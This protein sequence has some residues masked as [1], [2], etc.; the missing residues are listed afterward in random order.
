MLFV[1]AAV[2]V[3]LGIIIGRKTVN[4]SAHTND[5]HEFREN[6]SRV[7][8]IA[9]ETTDQRRTSS[10]HPFKDHR[11]LLALEDIPSP[12]QRLI[13]LYRALDDTTPATIKQ[14]VDDYL[15]MTK[16]TQNRLTQLTGN[17]GFVNAMMQRYGKLVGADSVRHLLTM[18]ELNHL[19]MSIRGF[20]GDNPQAAIDYFTNEKKAIPYDAMRAFANEIALA[21]MAK[22][23]SLREWKD[24]MAIKNEHN[25]LS[26]GSFVRFSAAT[27]ALVE[28]KQLNIDLS[29][30]LDMHD[31]NYLIGHLPEYAQLL[32]AKYSADYETE[33]NASTIHFDRMNP[34]ERIASIRN[35]LADSTLDQSRKI[36]C[37]QRYLSPTDYS[38]LRKD[39]SPI[40]KT[41]DH[42][43]QE[44]LLASNASDVLALNFDV[45]DM[46]SILQDETHFNERLSKLI[47]QQE[48][49]ENVLHVTEHLGT[50]KRKQLLYK[51]LTTQPS[52]DSIEQIKKW[53][54]QAAYLSDQEYEWLQDAI[55]RQEQ[56]LQ[57]ADAMNQINVE[58]ENE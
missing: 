41:L 43:T 27:T 19:G 25:D 26:D 14:M 31:R 46:R 20:A 47:E 8:Q 42:E 35:V 40:W 10:F 23:I 29:E 28:G 11:G 33:G 15:K 55:T 52:S 48:A 37:M 21:L 18:N 4:E 13:A 24:F 57:A 32:A 39:F 5:S 56:C 58:V 38:D 6:K 51:A 34:T 50:Q 2:C 12:E 1:C 30:A 53:S 54:E 49:K 7:R 44:Q 16:G 9:N 17:S 45:A 36:A 3:L 22:K